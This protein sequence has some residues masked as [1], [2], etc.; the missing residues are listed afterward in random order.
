MTNQEA[1]TSPIKMVFL[2]TA[3]F[4]KRH[5]IT[6]VVGCAAGTAGTLAVQHFSAAQNE[7]PQEEFVPQPE[8]Y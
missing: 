5:A 3:A 7:A 4:I 6:F 8:L 1:K 2:K